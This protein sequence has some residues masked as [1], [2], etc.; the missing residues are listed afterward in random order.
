M[1]DCHRILDFVLN[2]RQKH[3]MAGPVCVMGRS[4]GSAS[5]IELA[6]AR[7]EDMDCL[8]IES[9]F[10]QTGPLLMVL[11]IDPE[12]IGLQAVPGSENVDKIQGFVKPCLVIHAEYDHIIPFSDGL[13]LYESVGS[14][15]KWLYEVKG[16]NHNDIFLRGMNAYLDHVRQICFL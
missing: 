16:A 11:G 14:E 6:A 7:S 15:K 10:A 13:A 12:R 9:G 2:Y 8:I 4:L 1:T 5:A 3:G